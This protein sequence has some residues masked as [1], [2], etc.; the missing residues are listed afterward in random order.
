[1]TTGNILNTQKGNRIPL[2]SK[3]ERHH[4][5]ITHN[6]SSANPK[7]TLSVIIPR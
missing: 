7:E 6:P 4:H 1:M 2:G 5:V 3:A